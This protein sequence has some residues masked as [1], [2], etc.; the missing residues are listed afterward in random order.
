MRS[1]ARGRVELRW[2]S[3]AP[4]DAGEY[5]CLARSRVGVAEKAATLTVNCES[6]MTSNV[7]ISR[8]I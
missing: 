1:L 6:P 8:S 5:V 7:A 3:V 2:T 4:E